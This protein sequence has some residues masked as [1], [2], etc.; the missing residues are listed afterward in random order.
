MLGVV[1]FEASKVKGT[2]STAVPFVDV[3]KI[4]LAG[5]QNTPDEQ[6]LFANE[7]SALGTASDVLIPR[8]RSV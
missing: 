6:S 3:V 2:F 1:L 4:A 5:L 7:P 8:P